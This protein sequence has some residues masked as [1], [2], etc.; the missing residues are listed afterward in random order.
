M[1][2]ASQITHPC[3]T[4]P[5]GGIPFEFLDETYT[6]KT[7][8][9]G[10]LYGENCMILTSTVF[11]W[12]TS[13]TDR[14]TDRQTD[15]RYHIARSACCRALKTNHICLS[16]SPILPSQFSLSFDE[17]LHRRLEPKD[18]VH[19]GQNPTIPSPIFNPHNAFSMARFEHHTSKACGQTVELKRHFLAAAVRM[20]V[21]KML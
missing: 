21:I 17:T 10:L 1:P 6:V 11:D 20:A 9:M 7:R 5:L 19:W 15:G 3:L 16:V 18:Q 4:P 13:V 12:S 8:G 2:A 14:R